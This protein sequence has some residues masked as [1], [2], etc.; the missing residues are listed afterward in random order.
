MS[1]LEEPAFGVVV[2]LT[3]VLIASIIAGSLLMIGVSL[4]LLALIGGLA[5]RARTIERKL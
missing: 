1:L 4:L 3:I 5:Y 2:L